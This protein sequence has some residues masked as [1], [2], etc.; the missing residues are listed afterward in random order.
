M[1]DMELQKELDALKDASFAKKTDAQLLAI[2]NRSENYKG[3]KLT[4]EH[5]KK[6]IIANNN[7]SAESR[8]KM[9]DARKGRKHD[10]ATLKKMSD[11][12]KGRKLTREHRKKL[13]KAAIGRKQSSDTRRKKAINSNSAK[14][15]FGVAERI[16]K[17]YN[18]KL[19]KDGKF[20]ILK[21]FEKKYNVSSRNIA[22]IIANKIW[23]EEY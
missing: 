7:R 13:S 3:R 9:S 14:L 16:R 4:A 10:A 21:Y 12:Q 1:R 20:G 5:R 19:I 18:D 11:A 23:K 2:E 8:K 17:E 6:I 22:M 15:S